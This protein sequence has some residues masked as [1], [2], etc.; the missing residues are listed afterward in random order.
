[1][2]AEEFDEAVGTRAAVGAEQA[3]AE[4]KNEEVKNFGIFHGAEGLHGVLFGF[5]QKGGERVIEFMWK[6]GDG[7]LF[8]DDSGGEGLVG[9]G[10]GADGCENIG[11][12]G[13]WQ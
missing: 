8:I 4:E 12:G 1:M 13:C 10:E 11:V 9:V 2:V 5:V 3:H 7:R 6:V